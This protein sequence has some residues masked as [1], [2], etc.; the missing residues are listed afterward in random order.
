M[1]RK[2]K[3]SQV[4]RLKKRGIRGM[5]EGG[6]VFPGVDDVGEASSVDL[7]KYGGS[8]PSGVRRTI[9]GQSIAPSRGYLSRAAGI[10]LPSGQAMRNMLLRRDGYLTRCGR[11]NPHTGTCVPARVGLR[12]PVWRTATWFGSILTFIAEVVHG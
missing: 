11:A 3:P 6:L 4:K 12:Y 10:T 1:K 5:Q 2:M 9:M 7:S 8:L